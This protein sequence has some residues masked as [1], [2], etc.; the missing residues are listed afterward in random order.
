[1]GLNENGLVNELGCGNCHSGVQ[2]SQIIKNRSP[3]LNYSG[4]KYNE[5]YLFN[6]LESPQTVRNH[7]GKSR[8]PNF[9][10]STDEAYALTL[11][12]MLSLIHI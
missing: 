7:I 8:M 11:Y 1:M 2:T 10:L 4:L 12:L 3:D 9:K 5:A 6:Y